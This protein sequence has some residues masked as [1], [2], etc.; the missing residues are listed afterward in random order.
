MAVPRSSESSAFPACHSYGH[1]RLEVREDPQTKRSRCQKLEISA[2]QIKSQEDMCRAPAVSAA[3]C[4]SGELKVMCAVTI[5][6]HRIKEAEQQHKV[7]PPHENCSCFEPTPK[8]LQIGFNFLL[9]TLSPWVK[10]CFNQTTQSKKV[11]RL[12]RWS[13]F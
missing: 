6:S 10:S 13:V 11:V 9:L 1:I 4:F 2:M 5:L 12:L 8:I 7:T 3:T